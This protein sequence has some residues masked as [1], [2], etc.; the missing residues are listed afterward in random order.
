MIRKAC[1]LLACLAGFACCCFGQS[2]KVY[3]V[4][5]VLGGTVY[6]GLP[7]TSTPLG[8]PV[9]LWLDR[10]GT[11]WVVDKGN[12]VI[13]K[14][15]GASAAMQATTSTSPG[16]RHAVFSR[17]LDVT[18]SGPAATTADSGSSHH[19]DQTTT[20]AI[21]RLRAASARAADHARSATRLRRSHASNGPRPR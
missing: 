5:T 7:A 21:P 2:N 9:G 14:W 16:A 11:L 17:R 19:R 6:D 10:N 3:T 13:W 8:S 4:D 1:L 18:R 12:N 20:E 15:S